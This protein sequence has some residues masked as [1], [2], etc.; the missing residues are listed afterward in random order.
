[1]PLLIPDAPAHIRGMRWMWPAVAPRDGDCL[2]VVCIG[3][4]P[5]AMHSRGS[6]PAAGSDSGSWGGLGPALTAVGKW[7]HTAPGALIR[8]DARGGVR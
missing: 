5:A 4:D 8:P 6:R 3:C 1:M 7:A 2:A